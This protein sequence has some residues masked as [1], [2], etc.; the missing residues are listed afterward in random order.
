MNDGEVLQHLLC[1]R[2]HGNILNSS[3][4]MWIYRPTMQKG[5][6]GLPLCPYIFSIL[7]EDLDTA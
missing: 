6:G 7:W 3:S 1:R 2:A 5:K 4:H